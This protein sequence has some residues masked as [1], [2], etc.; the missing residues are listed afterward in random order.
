MLSHFVLLFGH[1]YITLN[2][3]NFQYD[4]VN[5][6]MNNFSF[7][8]FIKQKEDQYDEVFVEKLLPIPL[9][10]YDKQLIDYANKYKIS[11]SKVILERYKLLGE[12]K[13]PR[14]TDLT[15]RAAGRYAKNKILPN[16]PVE[17]P[18]LREK[19]YKYGYST[20]KSIILK[21]RSLE[22]I[23][24]NFILTGKGKV[25]PEGNY[26]TKEY[27]PNETLFFMNQKRI[28]EISEEM[29][30]KISTYH[31]W[32]KEFVHELKNH[33]IAYIYRS[34][35]RITNDPKENDKLFRS[36]A[37]KAIGNYIRDLSRK[38]DQNQ[39]YSTLSPMHELPF[40]YNRK[41]T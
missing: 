11:G 30:Q 27:M 19:V 26:H 17:I 36:I 5:I 21:E 38:Y 28:N 15:F 23:I 7:S 18:Q 41:S 25:Q 1:T 10:E 20:G 24:N 32:T 4:L 22:R 2:V 13:S 31:P 39:K 3:I 6:D 40:G 16:A 14:M 9:D 33:A 34:S 37:S 8:E 35:S 12:K 29:A